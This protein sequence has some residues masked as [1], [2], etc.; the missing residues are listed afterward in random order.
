MYQL[1]AIAV[2][3]CVPMMFSLGIGRH[4][5]D[6]TM[7]ELLQARKWAWISQI[8]YYGAVGTVKCSIV[9]LYYRLASKKNH[10]MVLLVF[11]SALLGHTL[12]ACITTAGMCTP[13]SIVWQPTFPVGCINLLTF[14]YFNA[15]FHIT[16]DLL[17]AVAPIPILKGLQVSSRKKIGL[18]IV[19]AVGALT[20]IGTIARQVTNAIALTNRDFTWYVVRFRG[21]RNITG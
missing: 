5:A 18:V 21:L 11:G 2:I 17:I 4:A 15:A 20:I 7:E 16:T 9:S 12:A 10:K 19:F 14:N 13:I 6:L 3:I 8:F 1:N